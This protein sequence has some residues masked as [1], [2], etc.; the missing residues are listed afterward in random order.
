MQPIEIIKHMKVIG[1]SILFCLFFIM[2][3]AQL[4]EV[5]SGV[6]KWADLPVKK[7]VQREG[8]KIMEGSSPHFSFLEVHATTQEKGAKPAPPHTQEDIEEVIIVKEG[9]MKMTMD[10][11][12]HVLPAGSVILIPPL[13]EQSLQNVGDGPL[14]YYV[15]MFKS[16]AKT[17][18]ERGKN[19]GGA[20]FINYDDLEFQPSKKGGKIVYLRRPTAMCEEFEMHVTQLDKKG[21][22]HSPH[23]HVDSEMILVID[24]E[25]QMNIAG[26]T[27]SGKAG[28]LY[29][30]KSN[31]FHGISNVGDKPCRYFAFRWY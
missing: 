18:I 28:D 15:M 2:S 21:P 6:Y 7:G 23:S 5:K 13:V 1:L 8:R 19:A 16:K 12:S 31:E 30:M 25:T 27:Y 4:S 22:S 11:E 20:M 29:F 9:L 24:G 14:T 10:G 3:N 26:N 17:D